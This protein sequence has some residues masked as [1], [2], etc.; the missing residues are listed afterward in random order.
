MGKAFSEGLTKEK[1]TEYKASL[2]AVQ[3]RCLKSYPG[4][5]HYR[6][7]VYTEDEAEVF[8]ISNLKIKSI[9]IE[10]EEE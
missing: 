9:K 8:L 7:F 3:I 5:Y 1:P 6:Q 4:Q 10:L 2:L